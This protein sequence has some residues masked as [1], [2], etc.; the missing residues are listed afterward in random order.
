MFVLV[1]ANTKND[2]DEEDEEQES[3]Q[4]PNVQWFH[5]WFFC[6]KKKKKKQDKTTENV[7]LS[8]TEAINVYFFW[9]LSVETPT[10][11]GT[12]HCH[13]DCSCHGPNFIRGSTVVNTRVGRRGFCDVDIPL[14][15]PSGLYHIRYVLVFPMNLRGRVSLSTAS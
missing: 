2:G 8:L 10:P 13:S 6:E 3:Y 15:P 9:N 1:G 4:Q 11:T 7:C 5:L 12:F 14:A